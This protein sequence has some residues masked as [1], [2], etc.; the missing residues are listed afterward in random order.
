MEVEKDRETGAMN[1]YLSSKEIV[2][3]VVALDK[4][5]SNDPVLKKIMNKLCNG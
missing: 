5:K 3:L 4:L 1:I 2:E